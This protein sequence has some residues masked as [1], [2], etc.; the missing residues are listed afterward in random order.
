MAECRNKN[1]QGRD[2]IDGQAA[3]RILDNGDQL[4]GVGCSLRHDLPELGQVAAQGVDRLRPLPDQKLTDA[5]DHRSPLGLFTLHGHETHRRALCGF[6][7]RLG[8][9]RIVLL[10]LHE[11]LD[12]GGRDEPC[13]LYTSP[14]PRDS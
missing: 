11:G 4:C 14:S 7:D 8:I 13:L 10:A 3:V 12:V 1:L 6:A 2:G 5:E 9:G